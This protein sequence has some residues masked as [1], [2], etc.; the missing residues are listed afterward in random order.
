LLKKH[1]NVAV[2]EIDRK[3]LKEV[4]DMVSGRAAQLAGMAI[5][6]TLIKSGK[7]HDA[8]VAVDGSVFE[9]QPGF[10]RV[11]ER[12]ITQLLGAECRVRLVL[13]RDGSGLGAGFIAALQ[14]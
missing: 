14:K 6:A 1:F 13:T 10:K 11:M 2:C 12:T 8:T 4:C 7:Q 9:K 5:A 3:V